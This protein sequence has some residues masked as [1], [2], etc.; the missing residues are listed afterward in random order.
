M[1]H[2]DKITQDVTMAGVGRA[3]R[4][5]FT[6][7]GRV[8]LKP[9]LGALFPVLGSLLVPFC[10]FL[11][12]FT[13]LFLFPKFMMDSR[14]L[15]P[16]GNAGRVVSI[17]NMG[18]KD[19][20][21]EN[22]DQE[23]AWTYKQ[24]MDQ[25][26][27]EGHES[28]EELKARIDDY[29]SSDVE[30]GRVPNQQDQ[31]YVHRLPWSVLAGV[32]R[33]SGDPI[34]HKGEERNPNPGKHFKVLRP[35]FTWRD[36]RVVKVKRLVK[37]NKDG[38]VSISYRTYS[39]TIKLLDTAKTFEAESY[40]YHWVEE[41]SYYDDGHLRSIMPK[42]ETVEKNGPYF[43]PLK[44]LMAEYNI[45]DLLEIETVLELA[46]LYDEEYM[47]DAGIIGTRVEGFH[48]DVTKQYYNGPKGETCA[49]VPI[50][51]FYISSPFGMRIHPT[52]KVPRMHTGI[53]ISAPSGVPAYS[54]FNGVVIWSGRKGGYGNCVMVDHGDIITLYGHLSVITASRGREVKSGDTVGLIGSTGVSTGPHLHFEIIK[55][56]GGGT[57]Y[58]D[59]K[60]YF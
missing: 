47:V 41:K 45:T 3:A 35:T 38:S 51:Y 33:M 17:Y 25:S 29:F 22:M 32:D 30:S 28:K 36:F 58:E 43:K 40:K 19:N 39:A 54:A 49:P 27:K 37:R 1:R 13:V 2:D 59:P 24:L 53:D 7:I 23:L 6:F 50:K 46:E 12:I 8:V 31:A 60:N 48:V 20:W 11:I 15:Q 26:Y 5:G 10:L 55:K 52:L 56:V 18:E 57:R 14:N 4:S 42:L 34:I 21:T 44:N 16:E 9:L